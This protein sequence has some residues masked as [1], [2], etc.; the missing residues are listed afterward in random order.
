MTTPNV[1]EENSGRLKVIPYTFNHV[2][3]VP[4]TLEYQIDCKSSGTLIRAATALTPG[5]T[6]YVPIA[7]DD[8][9]L[10]TQTK[11]SELREVTITADKDLDTQFRK[12]H[13]YL[14]VNKAAVT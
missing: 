12:T 10:T 4:T 5:L 7:P 9:T 14:V 1:I 3:A 11:N 8:T 13:Q 6:V 2:A